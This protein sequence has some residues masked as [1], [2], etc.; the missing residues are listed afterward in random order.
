MIRE[1][2]KEK[3]VIEV[4]WED[5]KEIPCKDMDIDCLPDELGC[6]PFGSYVR[7]YLYDPEK[8]SCPFLPII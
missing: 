7:C 6:P 3:I 2:D 4:H 1:S 5:K 8:G